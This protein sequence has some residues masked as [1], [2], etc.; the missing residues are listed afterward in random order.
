MVPV[1]SKLSYEDRLKAMDLPSPVYR[2]IRG[3]FIDI[4]KY[5][6]GVYRM[7]VESLLPLAKSTSG[8]A[9][10]GHSRNWRNDTAELSS[11]PIQWVQNGEFLELAARGG[12]CSKV[13]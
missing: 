12:G 6:R 9:T 7:N 1:L 10:R 13:S 5:L 2:R 8:V 3:D 11:G 4:Y